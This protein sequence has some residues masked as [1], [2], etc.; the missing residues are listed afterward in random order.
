MINNNLP[1][2]YPT[3]LDMDDNCVILQY[4]LLHHGDHF[5]NN[6]DAAFSL[7]SSNIVCI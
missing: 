2:Y 3:I 1:R 5:M 6:N 7:I 4:H